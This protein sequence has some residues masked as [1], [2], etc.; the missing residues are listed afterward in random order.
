MPTASSPGAGPTSLPASS[1]SSSAPTSRGR[2]QAVSWRVRQARGA[3]G[4]GMCTSQSSS[5]PNCTR[6]FILG[7]RDCH[8]SGVRGGDA[9]RLGFSAQLSKRVVTSCQFQKRPHGGA[10]GSGPAFPAGLLCL[11]NLRNQPAADE[12]APAPTWRSSEFQ[13]NRAYLRARVRE[14]AVPHYPLGLSMAGG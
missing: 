4:G 5:A 6:A 1:L 8:R 12:D 11:L 10:G 3:R 7:H 14:G 2:G 9:G 13:Q